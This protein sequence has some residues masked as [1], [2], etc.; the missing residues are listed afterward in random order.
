VAAVAE[1]YAFIKSLWLV[2]CVL[3]FAGI[4]AWV[5]W[6]GRKA[7]LEAHGRIPLEDDDR[8]R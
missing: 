1:A 7:S 5:F 2:W 8:E 4:V 6:P 3:L